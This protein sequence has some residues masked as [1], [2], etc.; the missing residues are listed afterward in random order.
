MK[1]AMLIFAASLT[2]A[3]CGGS[4]EQTSTDSVV[5]PGPDS[6][7]I[8]P[9]LTDSAKADTV[10]IKSDEELGGKPAHE[11]PIK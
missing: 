6:S 2:L 5:V 7:V 1:K 8:L 10:S 9:A 3:A 11:Q 4:S